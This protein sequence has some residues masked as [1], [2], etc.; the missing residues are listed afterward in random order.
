MG[1][2]GDSVVISI[3]GALPLPVGA[4][5]ST[6]AQ[7]V[8]TSSHKIRPVVGM[9]C[10]SDGAT[11]EDPSPTAFGGGRSVFNPYCR[12]FKNSLILFSKYLLLM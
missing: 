8:E 2:T 6:R 9:T 7:V 3:M 12:Q 10:F 4:G 11:R 1:E 5:I